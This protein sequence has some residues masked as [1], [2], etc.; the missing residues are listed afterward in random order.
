[1][2]W[3]PAFF[4]S[5]YSSS[6]LFLLFLIRHTIHEWHQFFLSHFFH[7]LLL[8]WDST[9]TLFVAEKVFFWYFFCTLEL[10]TIRWNWANNID[11]IGRNIKKQRWKWVEEKDSCW[12]KSN[13]ISTKHWRTVSSEHWS[14]D[15]FC[16]YC[17]QFTILCTNWSHHNRKAIIYRFDTKSTHTST[18]H[19]CEFYL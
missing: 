18:R 19:V 2:F 1:M 13:A 10:S 6:S 3:L 4:P 15:V 16:L 7:L 11:S 8:L 17:Y 12:H 14:N 5:S 9:H